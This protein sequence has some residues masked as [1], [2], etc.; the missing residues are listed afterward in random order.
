MRVGG[1]GKE[2][3]SLW[4]LRLDKAGREEPARCF[5]V[6]MRDQKPQVRQQQLQRDE[7]SERMGERPPG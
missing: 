7:G 3:G 2:G 1:G 6:P 5:D 4:G